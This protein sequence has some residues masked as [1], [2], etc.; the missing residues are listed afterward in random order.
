[1]PQFGQITIDNQSYVER[2]QIFPAE[3]EVTKNFQ[4]LTQQ[5]VTLT[6]VANFLLKGLTREITNN[7]IP[8]GAIRFKFRFGNSDGTNWYIAGGIGAP[9]DRVLDTLCFGSGQFIYPVIPP[10]SYA[11]GGSI[12]FEIEDIGSN[13]GNPLFVFPYTINLGFHGSYLIPVASVPALTQ[14]TSNATISSS[15]QPMLIGGGY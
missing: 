7:G 14:P 1:M 9:S 2:L 13:V 4:I 12:T 3:V 8:V 15:Y 5:K 11:A 10:I 6:G